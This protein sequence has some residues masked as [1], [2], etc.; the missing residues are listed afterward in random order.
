MWASERIARAVG[1]ASTIRGS[2]THSQCTR[3]ALAGLS[4]KHSW[5]TVG[6]GEMQPH[7]T[8]LAPWTGSHYTT[9][10]VYVCVQQRPYPCQGAEDR[11]AQNAHFGLDFTKQ[12]C[13]CKVPAATCTNTSHSSVLRHT[14][15]AK[16]KCNYPLLPVNASNKYFRRSK[17]FRLFL[18]SL[19]TIMA[20]CL[21]CGGMLRALIWDTGSTSLHSLVYLGRLEWHQAILS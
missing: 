1:T 13:S 20:M 7:G 14:D 4:R 5:S 6:L 11:G 16:I 10:S 21:V 2:C 17:T 12:T 19:R 8:Q 15:Q 9:V 18:Q 3:N